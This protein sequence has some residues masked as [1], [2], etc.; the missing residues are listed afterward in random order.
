MDGVMSEN[1]ERRRIA[2]ENIRAKAEVLDI[3]HH[4]R[5]VHVLEDDRVFAAAYLTLPLALAKC[6]AMHSALASRS[7]A[8]ALFRIFPHSPAPVSSYR[9]IATPSLQVTYYVVMDRSELGRSLTSGTVYAD[10][11][12]D[13]GSPG[14]GIV[15]A[16][17]HLVE[18]L[19]PGRTDPRRVRRL[20]ARD[21]RVAARLDAIAREGSA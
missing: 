19:W 9:E 12:I 1:I 3:W 11:D 5:R 8:E 21:P 16:F 20:I 18:V 10:L 4:F 14:T 15:G 6:S 7:H 2:H 17:V 13:L